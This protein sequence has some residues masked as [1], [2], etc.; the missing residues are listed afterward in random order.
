VR[1]P[2]GSRTTM[3]WGIASVIR[4]SSRS[5]SRSFV[6]ALFRSSMSVLLPNHLMTLPPASSCGTTRIRNHRYSPSYLRTRVSSSPGLRAST[7]ASNSRRSRFRSSGGTATFQ[8]QPFP[9]SWVKPVYSYRRLFR[10]SLDP[11]GKLVHKIDGTVS[12]TV[13][14]RAASSPSFLRASLSSWLCSF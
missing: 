6:S 8:S 2:F 9:C 1:C 5:S 11:S 7:K 14:S 12:M 13:W 4:R 3:V 10:Y